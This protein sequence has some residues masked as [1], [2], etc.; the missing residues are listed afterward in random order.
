MEVTPGVIEGQEMPNDQLHT[1][2]SAV[3]RVEIDLPYSEHLRVSALP[4]KGD[5]ELKNLIEGHPD[6]KSDLQEG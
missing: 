1:L 2:L 6:V 4:G 3:I 5:N